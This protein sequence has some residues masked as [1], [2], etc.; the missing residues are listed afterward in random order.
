MALDCG[1]ARLG[2]DHADQHA[3]GAERAELG[4]VVD[5]ER[6]ALSPT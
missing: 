5:G 2:V 3:T 6:A 4:A 1:S